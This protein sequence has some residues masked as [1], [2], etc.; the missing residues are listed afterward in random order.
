MLFF[1]QLFIENSHK[2]TILGIV[3]E[4]VHYSHVSE[5]RPKSMMCKTFKA[6]LLFPTKDGITEL[7]SFFMWIATGY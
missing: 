6:V 2:G 4:L 3:P 7:P 1:K 5:V